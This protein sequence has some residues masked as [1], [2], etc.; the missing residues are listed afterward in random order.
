MELQEFCSGLGRAK[1][2]NT[3]KKAILIL[4]W[5]FQRDPRA[6]LSVNQ[7]A[8]IFLDSGLGNPNVTVLKRGLTISQ[9]VLKAEAGFRFKP[10]A[11]SVV[12]SWMGALSIPDLHKVF[13]VHGRNKKIRD[14]LFSF[15]RAIGLHPIEWS[16]A[17]IATGKPAPYVGEILDVAFS[18]ACA[19]VVLMTPDDEACLREEFRNHNDPVY[20]LELTGQARQNVIFEAGMAMGR[21]PLRTVLVEVGTLRPFSDIGGRHVI[22]LEDTTQG[23][24]ELAQRLRSAGCLVNLDGT[25]WHTVGQFKI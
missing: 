20:E 23:R 17:V 15:L 19:V 18:K 12:E 6:S 25:D 11:Q 16:Q 7:L 8:D 3:T 1:K 10:S 2:L 21:C 9:Y 24:Q 5:H 4:W 14:S 22:R 13:V